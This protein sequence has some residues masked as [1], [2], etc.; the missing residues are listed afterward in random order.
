MSKAIKLYSPHLPFV[1]FDEQWIRLY[2]QAGYC[3]GISNVHLIKE[4]FLDQAINIAKSQN[5]C[6]EESGIAGLALLLQ[7]QDQIPR[8]KKILIVNT[9]KTKY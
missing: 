4:K 6:C 3:G 5:I 8:D 7:M 1:H 2:C 9:G